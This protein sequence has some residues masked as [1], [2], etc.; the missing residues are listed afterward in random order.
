MS[1]FFGRGPR[2]PFPSWLPDD[3]GTKDTKRHEFGLCEGEEKIRQSIRLILATAPGERIMRPDFGCGI[4][5]LLFEPLTSALVALVSDRVGTALARWE[6]RIDV[7]NIGVRIPDSGSQ[8]LLVD[9]TYRT[10]ANN[11]VNNLVYPFYLQEGAG[12]A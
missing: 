8:A 7:L 9:I 12:A 10:R 3:Q 1:D 5:E 6:P 2:F 11:A 4:H